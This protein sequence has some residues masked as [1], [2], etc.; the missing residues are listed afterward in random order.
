MKQTLILPVVSESAVEFI[1]PIRPE[2]NTLPGQ[3]VVSDWLSDRK[4]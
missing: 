4:R 3:V 1:V 2:R